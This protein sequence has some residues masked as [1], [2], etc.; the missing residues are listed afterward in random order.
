M[1]FEELRAIRDSLALRKGWEASHP[2]NPR[3]NKQTDITDN[4]LIG[5]GI[6]LHISIS[7][8]NEPASVHLS[9]DKIRLVTPPNPYVGM[10]N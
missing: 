2:Q 1:V 3:T 7:I 4:H 8:I 10:R 5:L 6:E 9:K